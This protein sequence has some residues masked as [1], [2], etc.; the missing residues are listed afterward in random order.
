[1]PTWASCRL[2]VMPLESEGRVRSDPGAQT[3]SVKSA[4]ASAESRSDSPR[5][6]AGQSRAGRAADAPSP[7]FPPARSALRIVASAC[8]EVTSL[9]TPKGSASS[10][11]L[12]TAWRLTVEVLGSDDQSRQ[13]HAMSG[14]GRAARA[15]G[16]SVLETVEVDESAKE[17]GDM[18]LA[19]ANDLRD[20]VG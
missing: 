18:A 8:S 4:I 11:F 19:L 14:G 1:M 2:K 9:R 6:C 5:Q 16:Q 13:E 15:S 7:R 12:K 10:S 3:N 17:R 20:E